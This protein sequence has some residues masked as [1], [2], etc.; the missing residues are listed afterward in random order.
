M[1]DTTERLEQTEAFDR[2][3]AIERIQNQINAFIEHRKQF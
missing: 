2:V 3:L 1:N